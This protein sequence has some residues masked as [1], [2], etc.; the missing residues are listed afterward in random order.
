MKWT[1]VIGPRAGES[2][3]LACFFARH[4]SAVY[5]AHPAYRA[6]HNVLPNQL[7]IRT[8][9]LGLLSWID[10]AII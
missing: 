2:Q 3:T 10:W 5:M 7:A 4:Y 1:P 8:P 6:V 9:L